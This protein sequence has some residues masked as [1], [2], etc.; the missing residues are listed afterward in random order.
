MNTEIF[1]EYCFQVIFQGGRACTWA[2]QLKLLESQFQWILFIR[3][4]AQ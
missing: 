4:D 3:H 2:Q 1:H